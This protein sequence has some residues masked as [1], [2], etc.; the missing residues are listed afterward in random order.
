MSVIMQTSCPL[1]RVIISFGAYLPNYMTPHPR[2]QYIH[3]KFH[4]LLQN[5]FQ[6]FKINTRNMEYTYLQLDINACKDC[7]PSET[8]ELQSHTICRLTV[9]GIFLMWF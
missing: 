2:R 1:G 9:S 3:I 4:I 6:N 8:T 7:V 5:S